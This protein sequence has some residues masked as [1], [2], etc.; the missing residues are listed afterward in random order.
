MGEVTKFTARGMDVAK[1]ISLGEDCTLLQR[2][3]SPR[4]ASEN[5]L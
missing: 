4:L 2:A 3:F 5:Q 1:H